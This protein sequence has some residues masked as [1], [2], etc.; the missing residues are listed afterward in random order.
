MHREI[1]FINGRAPRMRAS[2]WVGFTQVAKRTQ[3]NSERRNAIK[4]DSCL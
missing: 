3:F 2:A 1:N 4:A